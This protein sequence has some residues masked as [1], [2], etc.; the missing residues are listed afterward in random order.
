MS[1]SRTMDEEIPGDTRHTDAGDSRGRND[2]KAPEPSA[3]KPDNQSPGEM[4]RQARLAAGYSV[5]EVCAQTMLATHTVEALEDDRFNE[6]SQPVFVR[7]YYRKCAKIL[8]VDIDQILRAYAVSGGSRVA[9][10][11]D[12]LGTPIQVVPAD[13]TPAKR[14]PF[15]FILLILIAIVV[16]VAGYLYWSQSIRNVISDSATTGISLMTEFQS[17][18]TGSDSSQS[19]SPQQSASTDKDGAAQASAS[20][21]DSVSLALAMQS[22][23]KKNAPDNAEKT[24]PASDTAATSAVGAEAGHAAA[25]EQAAALP[26]VD[27]SQESAPMA[28]PVSDTA[29]ETITDTR[30]NQGEVTESATGS[31]NPVAATSEQA[32]IAAAGGTALTVQFN[33]RSW[34]SIQDA[35]GQQLLVGIYEGTTRTLDGVPPYNLVIGYAPGVTVRYQG[36]AVQFNVAGNDTARFTVGA[37]NS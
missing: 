28:E 2:N 27:D 16:A 3:E 33:E 36:K 7:G 26:A 20:K 1:E 25:N 13:V 6:L 35:S 37:G 17:S 11:H 30:D 4:L 5:A 8:D 14:R 31:G 24:P 21:D 22:D 19:S 34:V 12:S 29:H 15:G 18:E 23:S 10:T 32:T 9:V